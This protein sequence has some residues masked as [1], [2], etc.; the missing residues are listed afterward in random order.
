MFYQHN[1]RIGIF[2][3]FRCDFFELPFEFSFVV[4]FDKL[5][6]F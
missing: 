1:H 2:V 4:R 6:G 5:V 3:Q